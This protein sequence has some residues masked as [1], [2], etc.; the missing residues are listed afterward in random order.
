MLYF[1]R[2]FLTI[3]LF[4][5]PALLFSQ[6]VAEFENLYDEAVE[7]YQNGNYEE[8]EE[9]F[10]QVSGDVC[11]VPKLIEKCVT[12]KIYLS[13]IYRRSRNFEAAEKFA[14]EAEK[15]FN[16][17]MTS[18]HPLESR[19]YLQKVYLYVDNTNFKK[20]REVANRALQLTDHESTE[21]LSKARAYLASAYLEEALGNYQQS[22]EFYSDAV[23]SV[24]H[25]EGTWD[26][27]KLLTICYNNMGILQR[28][29]GNAGE[30]MSYYQKGIEVTQSLYGK[31]HP[32]MA[33]L[34]NNI[35]GVY[36]S[37]GDFGQ[38]ADHFFRAA[39][40]FR[41]NYGE[42]HTRVAGGF[43]NA[44]VAYLQM[45]DF[46]NGTEM[47]ERAQRIKEEV[48]GEDHLDTA[49]GYS[50]L[51]YTYLE[52]KDYDAA[53]ENYQKSLNVRKR[54]YGQQ[55]PNLIPSYVSLGEFYAE[56][57]N[58]S[59][60]REHFQQAL[61]IAEN[62]LGEN[63]PDV[64]QVILKL[65][66]SYEKEKEY[67]KALEYYLQAY[68]SIGEAS[69][70]KTGSGIDVGQLTHPLVLMDAA[71]KVGN[72]NIKEFESTGQI[73]HLYQ[74]VDHYST[75]MNIVDFLQQSYQNE[76]SKLNLI[77]QNYSI[78]TNTIKAYSKL[79][80][81]TGSENWLDEI[82]RI[83]EL[84]RSRIALEL[85]QDLEAKTFARV[86]DDVLSEEQSIN[87]KI[88]DYYQQL[89]TEQEKGLEANQDIISAYRDSLFISR[90]NLAAFTDN[91]ER[92]YP[93]Y[94]QLK[95][96]QSFVERETVSTILNDNETLLNYVVS[97]EEVYALVM[98]NNNISFYSLG[99]PD[100]LSSQIKLLRESVLSDNREEYSKL[101][102]N[103]YRKLIDPVKPSVQT[104]SLIIIPDQMLHYLPF[105]MLLTE[106][107]RGADYNDMSYL[108]RDYEISYVSSAT[109][110]Q[111]LTRQRIENPRNLFAVAPF[112][113]TIV[114][115]SN[116]EE[117]SRYLSDLSPL[118]LT[119]YE[120][121]QIAEIFEDSRS[122]WSFL[123]PEK[124]EILLGR[125][126]SK[127]TIENTTLE[128]YGFIHFATHAFV[129]EGNPALSGIA[130]WGE[131]DDSGIIYVNDIYNLTMNADLV[132]LGACETGLGTVYK[133][134]GIIG[135]TRAFM[136]AGTANL[137][138]SMWRV[139]DQ[140][141][142]NLMIQFY[143]Y[144]REGHSYSESLQMAKM[145]LINQPEFAAPRNWAA[146]VLQGR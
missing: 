138:V 58:Y 116:Q 50:N 14:V 127:T 87:S 41:E 15:A 7:F 120:T 13:D 4:L 142:A 3:I 143:K 19:L 9:R 79:Y 97:E 104:Q 47:L 124:T 101:A 133:G 51:A 54:I 123:Y 65:G 52:N 12:S 2:N 128:E 27:L 49:I 16:E 30:A 130:F 80:E 85:L 121:R 56:I 39:N 53:L 86:P 46:E 81:E 10:S 122:F 145:D 22:F 34:Y 74:A 31:N 38:A 35:G 11:S 125:V 92:E 20:A 61:Q 60:G 83:S 25:I 43:N 111:K 91:L 67:E 23:E 103:L 64:W 18:P 21:E 90:Q 57:K 26:L 37:L 45:G 73:T 93:D 32:E 1:L 69:G 62:R 44:G 117:E 119:Q 59:L 100:S 131:E 146:F 129:N 36:Y 48:L 55:H 76:A 140:P 102:Y 99:S 84:S 95:Y 139:N 29:L 70:L 6:S 137:M 107:K 118:P 135:F 68:R 82:L 77:D 75:A 8:S 71:K 78:F 24:E 108:I 5:F 113:E 96:D 115:T 89:H 63:H 94:Y 109:V 105:E 134:E 28:Q 66:D 126:A 114:Q 136:Y 132:V 112:N 98:D 72:M 144:A 110:L 42:Y 17:R 33:L 141:T 106:Q 88:A 40:I